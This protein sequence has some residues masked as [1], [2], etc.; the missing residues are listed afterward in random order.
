MTLNKILALLSFSL[1]LGS[2]ASCRTPSE[3]DAEDHFSMMTQCRLMCGERKVKKYIPFSGEC[4]CSSKTST[5]LIRGE[6]YKWGR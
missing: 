6:S 5:K 2:F 4:I 3:W 1:I